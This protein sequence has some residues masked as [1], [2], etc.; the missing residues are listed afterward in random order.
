MLIG[1]NFTY[2]DSL[3]IYPSL[4][5][6]NGSYD[7]NRKSNSIATYN[8]F[9]LN[10]K[11]FLTVAFDNLSINESDW[12][13][14]QQSITAGLS[15]N[16]FPITFKGNYMHIKGDFEYLPFEF[17]YSDFTN[18]YNVDAT[19]YLNPFYTGLSYTFNNK[20]GL[21]NRQVHQLTGR[22]EYIPHYKFFISLKPSY[23]NL[24][25]GR[26]LY[27]IS[28]RMHYL[29]HTNFIIKAGGFAGE[30]AYYFD[31]DLLTIYN[32]DETQ[33]YQFFAQLDYVPSY[34]IAFILSYIHTGFS[35][36]K[37]NYVVAG[38]RSYFSL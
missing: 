22:I 18:I 36:Y 38:V 20:T 29:V 8:T 27:S 13:Y 33:K 24:N 15:F 1:S 19:V 17:P 32:Q 6:T 14:K 26:E 12:K 21:S 4:Y 25:D 28:L 11:S 30:R 3:S 37:I 5:Y 16:I 23:S 7:N 34:S 2:S 35:S 9:T 31:S 10:H